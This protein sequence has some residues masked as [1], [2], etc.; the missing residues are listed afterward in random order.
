MVLDKHL[1]SM[2][3]WESR[4]WQK[5]KPTVRPIGHMTYT[6]APAACEKNTF[7]LFCFTQPVKVDSSGT[8]I[9]PIGTPM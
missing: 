4:Q 3:G 7:Y 9:R 8:W 6:Q 2:G 1:K 5:T